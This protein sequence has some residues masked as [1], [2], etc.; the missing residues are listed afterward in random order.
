[1]RHTAQDARSLLWVENQGSFGVRDLSG[2]G[3]QMAGSTLPLSMSSRGL[4][5]AEAQLKQAPADPVE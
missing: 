1:M 4:N 3:L 2:A 5:K